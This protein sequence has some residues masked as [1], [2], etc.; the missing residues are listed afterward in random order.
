MKKWL[1]NALWDHWVQGGNE[2]IFEDCESGT[3]VYN[4]VNNFKWPWFKPMAILTIDDRAYQFTGT[5]PTP[6]SIRAFKPW[7]KR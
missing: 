3:D 4:L 5:F 6:E 7:N 1:R 2:S